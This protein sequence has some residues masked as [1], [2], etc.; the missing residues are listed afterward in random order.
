MLCKD[1]RLSTVVT[2]A[3]GFPSRHKKNNEKAQEASD[4]LRDNL[5]LQNF[6][7]NC[8]EVRLQ[9]GRPLCRRFLSRSK[10]P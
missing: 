3:S 8:Q 6:L 1:P 5:A 4:L 9:Q 2:T 10:V 7:Q